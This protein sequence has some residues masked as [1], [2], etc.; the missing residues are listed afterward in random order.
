MSN[1][2]NLDKEAKIHE[3]IRKELRHEY[4]GLRQTSNTNKSYHNIMALL[5]EYG[6]RRY[7]DGL[8]DAEEIAIKLIAKRKLDINNNL[9]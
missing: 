7:S 2:G 4:R 3:E 1:L 5:E 9:I 6:A 8:I